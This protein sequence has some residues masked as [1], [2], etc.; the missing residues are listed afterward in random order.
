MPGRLSTRS[1][2]TA[3]QSTKSPTTTSRSR[4]SAPSIPDEGP[5]T[6]LRIRVSAIFSDAQR[7]IASHRKLIVSLRKI[8]EACCYESLQPGKTDFGEYD[9]ND[10]NGEIA[11]CIV[12]LLPVKKT[13]SAA[14]KIIKFFGLFLTHASEKGLCIIYQFAVANSLQT[15]P[16][17]STTRPKR[18][19][20]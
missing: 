7:S 16:S 12:R 3:R 14:D 17:Y 9:E 2:A 10:F 6:D 8:H 4:I 11:R 13:E 18:R 19:K 20:L 1:S 15:R 5:S